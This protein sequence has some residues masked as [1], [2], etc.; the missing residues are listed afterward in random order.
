MACCT[1]RTQ[2]E[3][4]AAAKRGDCIH[5]ASG[6]FSA[7]GSATVTAYGSATV[8]ATDSA[9][10]TAYGSATVRAYGSATVRA[11]DSATVTAYDSATVMATDSATVRA[12]A[13]SVIIALSASV[14]ISASGM[15]TVVRQAECRVSTGGLAVSIKRV[16]ADLPVW[17]AAHDA[18][19]TPDDR[20]RLYKW[21]NENHDSPH[22]FRY[23]IGPVTSPDWDD[24]SSRECGGG[25]HACASLRDA[26]PFRDGRT[27]AVEILVAEQDIRAPQ[28]GDQYPSKVRFRCGEVVRVWK[29]TDEEVWA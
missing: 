10:V 20:L 29:P 11:T 25:L 14:V 16:I 3:F 15:A 4:D 22:G 12:Y 13:R 27:H 26:L 9:T 19:R 24:D 21:V 28:P 2:E 17:C 7:Y 5:V 8:R 23:V 18:A 6:D 1:V